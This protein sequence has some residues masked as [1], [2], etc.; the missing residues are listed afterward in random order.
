LADV[1]FVTDDVV[2]VWY[3]DGQ[4]CIQSEGINFFKDLPSFLV[5]LYALQRLKLEQ[6][7]LN[8]SLDDR[9]RRAHLGTFDRNSQLRWEIVGSNSTLQTADRKEFEFTR[10]VFH[11]NLGIIGRGTVAVRAT[12]EGGPP[13]KIYAVKISWPEE[14]RPNEAEILRPAMEKAG[15]DRDI[16]DH[17][18]RVFATQ[19]F[20]FRTGTVRTA[21]GFRNGRMVIPTPG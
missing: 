2:W 15:D 16:T 19:D 3:Y 12:L 13:D 18:P 5:L 10:Q 6:W 9:V 11:S 8:P 7:G 14:S 17:I 4:G 1:Y 21:L 20:P